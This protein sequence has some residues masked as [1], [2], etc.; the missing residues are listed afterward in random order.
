MR[1]PLMTPQEMKNFQA[2]QNSEMVAK[3]ENSAQSTS[4]IIL[5]EAAACGFERVY[6]YNPTFENDSLHWPSEVVQRSVEILNESGMWH[7]RAERVR[8]WHMLVFRNV[9]WR[10]QAGSPVWRIHIEPLK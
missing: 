3:L 2:A 10:R 5:N 6:L 8:F 7:V 4:R 9:N 1:Q